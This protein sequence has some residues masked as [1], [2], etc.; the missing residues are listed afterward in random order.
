M[1]ALSRQDF[2]HVQVVPNLGLEQ[3]AFDRDRFV[4]STMDDAALQ[5]EVVGLF[6]VQVDETCVRLTEGTISAEDRK[7]LGHNLRGA[8]AA[9]G[10][11]HIEELAKSW[12]SVSYDHAVLRE[13]LQ[14]A[15]TA[16]LAKARPFIS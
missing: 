1:R 12:E 4:M 15:K 3:P 10:A 13:L 6:I 7:F 9:V 11:L 5:R 16:F 14:Q 2:K 8:A